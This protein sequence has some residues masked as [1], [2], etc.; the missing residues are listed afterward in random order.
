MSVI[1]E[2]CLPLR[3]AVFLSMDTLEK[4]VKDMEAGNLEAY[5]KSEDVPADNSAPVKVSQPHSQG[6]H[7]I[8]TAGFTSIG[9]PIMEVTVMRS[10]SLHNGNSYTCKTAFFILNQSPDQVSLH[11][12]NESAFSVHRYFC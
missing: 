5:L 4:F 7:S 11:L 3:F 8:E 9:S 6:P 12:A 2:A 1:L 10:S